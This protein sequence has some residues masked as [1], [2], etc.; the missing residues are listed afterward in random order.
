MLP[1]AGSIAIDMGNPLDMTD[2][3]NHTVSG[4]RRDVGAAETVCIAT[5]EGTHNETVCFG[6]SITV[7]GTIY[8]ANNLTGT[9][10]FTNVGINNCD[11]L[12]TVTLTIEDEIDVSTTTS[13]LTV[14]A[15]STGATYQWLD[16]GNNNQPIAGATNVEYTATANGDYAVVVTV[17]SCS[18]TSPCV[19]INSIGIV[20][21]TNDIN[22]S[23][24]PNPVTNKLTIGNNEIKINTIS[25]LNITGG[26]VKTT[27]ENTNV[28]DVSNLT[29]GIYFVQIHTD[30]GLVRKKFVKE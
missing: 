9:E 2:A 26:V 18:G 19:N 23:I 27:T 15:N 11:S 5:T 13:G 30:N 10:V 21:Q 7:N 8:D 29:K 17:G 16:C 12:V 6:G 25:I 1:G 20:Q 24:Y 22:L 28:I 3:Q 4:G 14:T